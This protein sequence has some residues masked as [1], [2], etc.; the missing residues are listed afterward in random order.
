MTITESLAGST[1]EV[2]AEGFLTDPSPRTF[3]MTLRTR[4]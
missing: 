1:V 3:R 2:D 4:F